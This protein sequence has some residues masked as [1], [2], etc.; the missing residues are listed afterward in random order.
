MHNVPRLKPLLL[1]LLLLSV[2]GPLRAQVRPMNLQ[3]MAQGAGSI[4]IGTV[5][6]ARGAV[7]RGEYVTVSTFKVE[8]TIKG[9]LPST[10]VVRQYGGQVGDRG[11][12]VPHIRYFRTGERVL[13]ML[14]PPSSIGFT[15]PV[16]LNQ[17]IWSVTSSGAIAGVSDEALK[18]LGWLVKK[19]RLGNGDSQ[20]IARNTFIAMIR[21]LIGGSGGGR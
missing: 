18:G 14:Y 17:G 16:G 2:A 5:A 10:Y 11:M 12:I 21:D 15:N 8:Q 1:S 3:E 19:Y 4:F 6:E 9:T 20:T 13:V 7:E